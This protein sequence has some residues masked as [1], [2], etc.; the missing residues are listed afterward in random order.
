MHELVLLRSK[1]NIRS[2][3]VSCFAAS[4]IY[5]HMVSAASIE[6]KVEFT[7]GIV[8]SRRPG[9]EHC[10]VRS[11]TRYSMSHRSCFAGACRAAQIRSQVV[12]R[13]SRAGE[14]PMGN[15][16]RF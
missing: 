7:V 6:A 11:F 4:K 8:A 12:S 13:A 14:N 10:G 2:H 1:Q 3:G 16:E 15:R 5:V 9:C